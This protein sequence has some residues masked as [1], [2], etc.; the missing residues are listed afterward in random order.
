[1][2]LANCPELIPEVQQQLQVKWLGDVLQTNFLDF[3]SRSTVLQMKSQVANL[4]SAE[5]VRATFKKPLV[6]KKTSAPTKLASPGKKIENNVKKICVQVLKGESNRSLVVVLDT[7]CFLREDG[8]LAIRE[9]LRLPQVILAV[10]RVVLY[11]L[12]ELKDKHYCRDPNVNRFA[13]Y[14]A[15]QIHRSCEN[16]KCILQ[17]EHE[18]LPFDTVEQNALEARDNK[19]N[20]LHISNFAEYKTKEYQ[21]DESLAV[22]L[23]TNDISLCNMATSKGVVTFTSK[24]VRAYLAKKK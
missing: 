9:L 12:D 23:M 16:G 5:L 15:Q 19:F 22:A 13:Q 17:K 6:A 2:A 3:C 8:R 10:P 11:E 20:D 1:M 18:S 14:A 24:E 4:K 21:A 7:N